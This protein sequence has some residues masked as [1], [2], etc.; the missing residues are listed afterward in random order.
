MKGRGAQGEREMEDE[1]G[2]WCLRGRG[3]RGGG[4]RRRRSG[5]R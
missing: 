4:R 1:E 5:A 2:T 3:Y